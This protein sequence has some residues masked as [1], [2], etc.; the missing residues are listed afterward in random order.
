[1]K[2]ENNNNN[3]NSLRVIEINQGSSTWKKNSVGV[4]GWKRLEE[5]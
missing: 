5:E 1:M 2:N 3:K 4:L